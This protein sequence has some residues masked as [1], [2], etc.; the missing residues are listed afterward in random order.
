MQEIN[1]KDFIDLFNKVKE[2]TEYVMPRIYFSQEPSDEIKNIIKMYG[3]KY[4]VLKNGFLP[5]GVSA[6]ILPSEAELM[7]SSIYKFGWDFKNDN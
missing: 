5:T 2:A 4:D 3:Y 7:E 6:V 1:Q